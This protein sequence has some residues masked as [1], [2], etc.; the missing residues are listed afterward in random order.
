MKRLV[1]IAA[2][3]A[4]TMG[5]GAQ[6]LNVQSAI[7]DLKKNYLNKAKA[8]IDLACEHEGTKDDAKT[9]CYKGLIYTRIGAESSN[10][11]SKFKNLAPDWAEQA[12][13]AA[14][15][16]KRLDTKNEYA[17]ENNEVFSY[18]GNEFYNKA[19]GAY[20]G[21][22]Y[23][24]AIQLA[25]KAI[26]MFNNSG[27]REYTNEA[28]Y[29]AGIAAK[30]NNDNAG[31][32]NYYN[33][34]M[35]RKTDKQTV[36]RAMFDLYKSEGNKAEA[37]KVA[38]MY[39]KNCPN[40]YNAKLLMAEGYLLNENIEK[41]KEMIESA[42]EMTKETPDIYAQ[43]LVQAGAILEVTGD[44]EGAEKRYEESLTMAPNQFAANFSVGKMNFNRG[45]DKLE[46]AN[47][48]PPEDETGLYEKLIGES[49]DLFR[50]SINYF[51]SAVDY[52]D[53]LPADA[54]KAQT[55]NLFNCLNALETVYVRLEMYDD[56]KP[57][58]AR[59][60]EIKSQQ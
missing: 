42:L 11:K 43:I 10:P 23:T 29:I 36:Y 30:A 45:V 5:A 8:E 3:T 53:H 35:R 44:Y 27:R 19:I 26:T 34:L 15:E 37:M 58:K 16:C 48:V 52:I 56:L 40:D 57:I 12:Y 6:T 59:I 20:N 38:N 1:L 55:P 51:R 13:N 2:L 33:Q 32:K 24:E 4:L 50:K 17:K 22:N 9:W 46:A 28:L 7:Q 31:M 14:L 41:G 18:V 39:S 54:Q 47:Q 49:N 21:G 60:E 25:E